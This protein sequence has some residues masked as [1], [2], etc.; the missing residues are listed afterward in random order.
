MKS[1][2]ES[3]LFYLEL[4]FFRDVDV[5][6]FC[7]APLTPEP[8]Q[9]LPGL[10]SILQADQFEFHLGSEFHFGSSFRKTVSPFTSTR[11]P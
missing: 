5:S 8:K 6:P 2:L 9:L 7:P 1:P 10:E 3:G 4:I 11:R